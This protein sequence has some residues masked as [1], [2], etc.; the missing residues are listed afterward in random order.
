M[1]LDLVAVQR[2]AALLDALSRRVRP[3]GLDGIDTRDPVLGLLAALVATVD[4]GLPPV[5]QPLFIPE[6]SRRQARPAAVLT[7]AGPVPPVGRR[8]AARVVAAVVVAAAVLSVSGVAAAVSGDPLTPYK[9]VIN[10]VRGGYHDVVPNRSPAVIEPKAKAALPKAGAAKA[11]RAAND[12]RQ[13]VSR[14]AS[15][16]AWRAANGR[17]SWQRHSSDRQV[18]D[19]HGWN[20]NVFNSNV[21]NGNVS[22]RNGS[23]RNDQD[24]RQRGGSGQQAGGRDGSG[25]GDG[26]GTGRDSFGSG[27]HGD[28]SGDGRR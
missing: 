12:A 3:V 9:S 25:S 4:D 23:Y 22:G 8:H 16:N 28:R 2:D 27:G 1:S 24:H 5:D 18:S 20:R 7:L 10:V 21:F 11:E 13:D 19:R 17:R 6:Q 14:S 26:S 15:R